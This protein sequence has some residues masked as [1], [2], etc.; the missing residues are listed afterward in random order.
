[1]ERFGVYFAYKSGSMN[2][3]RHNFIIISIL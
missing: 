1:M 2:C 3:C